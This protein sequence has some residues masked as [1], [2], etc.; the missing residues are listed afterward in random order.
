MTGEAPHTTARERSAGKSASPRTWEG[1]RW[2]LAA[3]AVGLAGGM[4]AGVLEPLWQL[5]RARG[6][7]TAGLWLEALSFSLIT[8]MVLWVTVCV[9]AC[10]IGW[11]VA[12]VSTGWRSSVLPGPL[13][14]AGCVVGLAVVLAWPSQGRWAGPV[15]ALTVGV[16]A[17]VPLGWACTRVRATAV[18]RGLASASRIAVWPAG[19]LM[20]ASV[21]LQWQGRSRVAS[22]DGFWP[23][24]TSRPANRPTDRPPDVVFV[25]LDTLRVDRLGC[26][27]YAKPTSPH[28][29]AFAADA[30]RFTR[31][32]SPSVWTPPAHA[33]MFTG[34]H[35][36]QHGISWVRTW[37]E[38]RFSTLAEILRDRGYQ[39]MALSNNPYVSPETNL[40]Q[41]FERFADPSRLIY[42]TRSSVYSF[43][44]NVLFKRGPLGSL[45]GRWFLSQA[46]GNATTPLAARWLADRDRSKPLLMFINYMETHRPYDP[47]RVYRRQFV[48]PDDLGRS[49]EIDQGGPAV[50][51][52]MLAG[53]PVYTSRDL[54]IL[55]DLYDARVR[56]LDDHF[57]DLMR[58]LARQLDLDNTI[59]ILTSDHGENLGEH[60]MLDHQ[61]CIYNTLIHVPL[62]VRWPRAFRPQE[63]GRLVQTCDIFPTVL[64][65]V[66]ADVTQS[67]KVMAR[68]LAV[69]L[70]PQAGGDG[71]Y[72]FS[73]YLRAPAW[74]FMLVR[75][76]DP[77]FDGSRWEVGYRAVLGE[78][79]KLVTRSD[80][81][82]ELYDLQEDPAEAHNV[83]A[84]Y[85][86]ERIR[87]EQRLAAWRKSFKPFDPSQSTS[88][89]AQ[90]SDAE[91]QQRLRDLGYV[92]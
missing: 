38:D 64:A 89:R 2:F 72:A 10:V 15:W 87:M 52:Y 42:S 55:S 83:A 92:P 65:C 76:R 62:I 7:M 46:G 4:C 50:Y 49:Y 36:S 1:L 28:I 40:T 82:V 77:T 75:Q 70:Q 22:P 59:I 26:Y 68:S 21:G 88:P 19:V 35:D 34:L 58:V 84:K 51:Q 12:R 73:E 18:G 63:V 74:P 57:A 54:R 14:C 6:L 31:A 44:R 13:A 16:I 20:V 91:R 61:Y 56:E 79:W 71:R 85:R 48:Q 23:V 29:D 5:R 37:L 43:A 39:T 9:T 90:R 67:S 24:T 32:I 81:R 69:A 30:V 25:V 47:A 27:G 8:H 17:V 78:R 80:R 53:A 66:G 60:G 41:G 86:A 11:G 45:L 3:V 33:S